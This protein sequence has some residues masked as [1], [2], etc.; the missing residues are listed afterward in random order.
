VIPNIDG[1]NIS[2][3]TVKSNTVEEEEMITHFKRAAIYKSWKDQA[4]VGG[5]GENPS[6]AGNSDW[7]WENFFSEKI[8]ADLAKAFNEATAN[9]DKSLR[10]LGSEVEKGINE[11][12][13][14]IN[15]FFTAV[16]ES[17]RQN[18][19]A[20]NKR[21][22]LLWWKQTLFSPVLKNSYRN[23]SVILSAVAMAYDLSKLTDYVS[24]ESVNYL[25]LEALYDIYGSAINKEEEFSFWLTMI[26]SDKEICKV[27]LADLA[28]DLPERKPLSVAFA[29]LLSDKDGTFTE[30]TG[31][32]AN[33]KISLSDLAVWIFN[34]LQAKKLSLIK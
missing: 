28:D 29:N 5:I 34:D 23:Q 10:A 8:G 15:D 26:A 33:S 17:T 30:Q 1:L 3:P 7:H 21:S 19:E 18:A 16:A 4:D 27:I 11:Y 6:Y 20:N 31:I 25:L 9:Q 22:D 2:L 24:P 12:F 32:E 14:N 13:T